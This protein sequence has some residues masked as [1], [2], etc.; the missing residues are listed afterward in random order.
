MCL[1][2]P[3]E[4]SLANLPQQTFWPYPHVF[5]FRHEQTELAGQVQ[6]RL[7]IWSCRQ[8]YT[9][10][11]IFPDVFLDSP[12]ALTFTVSQV[13]AFIDDNESVAT[14]I[15]E[16]L[17][18]LAQRQHAGAHVVLLPVVLPHGD[19]ILRADDQCLQPVV[20]FKHSC[21]SGRHECLAQSD[22]IADDDA[23]APVQVVRGDFYGR[24]LEVQ[25]FVAEIPGD[26]KFRQTGPGFL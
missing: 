2:S 5:T 20:V 6:V 7:V 13:V 14:H 15:G 17:D 23:P 24:C 10:A 4:L 3:D 18:C 21:K 26:T 9:L 12:V 8:Q 1:V 11:V 22:D 16:F 25:Q 19:E